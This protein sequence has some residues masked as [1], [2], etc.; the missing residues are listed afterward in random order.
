MG[1]QRV[2]HVKLLSTKY[3]L[4]VFGTTDECMCKT[5]SQIKQTSGYQKGEGMEEGKL[6]I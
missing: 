3:I 4:K 1:L 5:D 2:G 6:G